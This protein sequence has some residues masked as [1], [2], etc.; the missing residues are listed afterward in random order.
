M[1]RGLFLL[2]LLALLLLPTACGSEAALSL[3]PVANAATKTSDAGSARMAF[4]MAM[5]MNGKT[6]KFCG[7]GMFDFDGHRGA[8]TMDM[9]SLLPRAAGRDGKFEVADDR[10][11]DLH[12]YAGR[13]RRAGGPAGS[14]G[15]ASTS[16]KALDKLGLGEHRPDEHAA[17]PDQD[18][19]SCCARPSTSV[20]K[21]G[22]ANDP[23]R[24]DDALHGG[25]RPA[26]VA[27]GGKRPAR[28]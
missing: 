6:T 23:R 12:A 18:A 26:E 25:A 8:M 27:R 10:Q 13:A 2:P 24:P 5:K 28:L 19:P 21:T 9:S 22:S 11:E 3:D 4:T 1:K 14:R 16:D 20:T 17:G 7:G 15:S